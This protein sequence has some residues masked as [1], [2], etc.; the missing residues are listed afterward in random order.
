MMT[1]LCK[2]R[3]RVIRAVAMVSTS[4]RIEIKLGNVVEE[5][6]HKDG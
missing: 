4:S 6:E 5:G 2:C 1:V 3:W